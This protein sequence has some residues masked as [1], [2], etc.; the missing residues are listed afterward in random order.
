MHD[1]RPI[2]GHPEHFSAVGHGKTRTASMKRRNK[3]SIELTSQNDYVR[4]TNPDVT[5][6]SGGSGAFIIR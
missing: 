6:E 3:S 2:N 4:K 5:R 1:N